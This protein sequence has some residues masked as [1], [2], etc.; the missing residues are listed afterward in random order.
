[1]T[2]GPK[3]LRSWPAARK[4]Q[5]FFNQPDTLEWDY[6]APPNKTLQGLHIDANLT[7]VGAG[8]TTVPLSQ[9]IQTL[10]IYSA[11]DP[12]QLPTYCCTI[13]QYTLDLAAGF[14]K[15]LELVNENIN[16]Y[17]FA[18]A[19]VDPPNVA[20]GASLY[21]RWK[22]Y[23]PLPGKG[24]KI[25]VNCQNETNVFGSGMTNGPLAMSVVPIWRDAKAA[26]NTPGA[27][28]TKQWNVYAKQAASIT[29]IAYQ[30]AYVAALFAPS[31]W[32]TFQSGVDLGGKLSPEMIT[33]ME[34]YFD[35][36]LVSYITQSAS[37]ANPDVKP[38]T[39]A[40]VN[41]VAD[42]WCLENEFDTPTRVTVGTNV[43]KTIKAIIFTDLPVDK[44]AV[45]Q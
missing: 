29:K 42:N 33:R 23:L 37:A 4:V 45:T 22:L 44:V 14:T 11:S 27:K 21:G 38:I 7:S 40:S 2:Q 8:M 16:E 13:D 41:P 25:V 19:Y 26:S 34:D 5:S 43:A 10:D 18:P 17:R 1:M 20:T 12:N 6:Q 35:D 31:E 28:A 3:L 9:A 15:Y 39:D 36:E 32:S 24:F 30:N